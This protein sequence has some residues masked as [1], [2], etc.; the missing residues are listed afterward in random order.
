[1]WF[2]DQVESSH[3]LRAVSAV[4]ARFPLD[5]TANGRAALAAL[6]DADAEAAISRFSPAIAEGLRREIAETRRTGI[7]FDRDEHTPGISAAAI[8]RQAVGDNVVAIS[9]P[10][11]T[12]RFLEKEQRIIAA[13]RTAAD[14]PA[15]TR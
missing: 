2:V 1:M 4:G 9:V 6:D 7:A 12:E 14:S 11:P 13:L 10:A 5:S 15:W 8:A 3:R